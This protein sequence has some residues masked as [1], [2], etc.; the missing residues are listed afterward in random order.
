MQ[1]D[2]E[3]DT[4]LEEGKT[5]KLVVSKGQ[6][7]EDKVSVP[8]VRSKT[9]SGAQSE[10]KAAGASVAGAVLLGPVGLVGGA[11]IK[12]KSVEYPAGT[13][14]YIQ[15]QNTVT[16][17]GL[18]IGGD[19]QAHSDDE[20]ADAVTST[21]MSVTSDTTAESTVDRPATDMPEEV[22]ADDSTEAENGSQ[23]IVVVKRT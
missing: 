18:V 15:P 23:P 9:K 19:G 20:L 14:M 3:S 6:K 12:G 10:L 8:D 22:V 16:I 5:I 21:P 7:I 13:E 17:Q 11:F 2:P 4:E 1:Q